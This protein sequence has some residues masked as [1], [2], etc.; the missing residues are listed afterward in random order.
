[1]NSPPRAIRMPEREPRIC[2]AGA[3]NVDL[4]AKVS[5]IPA[6]GETLPADAF[7]VDC[8]G[9]GGNQAVMARRLGARVTMASRVGRDVFGERAVRNYEDRGIDTAFVSWDD[10][11]PSGVAAI[12]VDGDGRNAIVY[13]PGANYALTPAHIRAAG[14][15]IAQAD[16]VV[17]QLEIPPATTQEALAIAR[18]ARRP[19]TIL[20]PAP[21]GAISGDL[22]ELCDV[23]VP[24]ELEAEALTGVAVRTLDDAAAAARRLREAGARAAV[25]TLG[26]R[27]ALIADE[28]GT[29]H[30]PGLRVGAVDTTG[31]GDA[32][33]GTLAYLLG[34]GATLR[35]AARFA[36]AAAALSVTKIGT[37]ASF[38]SRA[39]VEELTARLAN[40]T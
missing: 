23:I 31:A 3:T 27:G 12:L 35:E 26:A 8:G 32:F 24:N 30:I 9:K 20:N 11:Q 17:S 13:V 28:G 25:I 16:A 5:R 34:A 40:I 15:A 10:E 33:I 7:H 39:E 29:A 38:P 18:R 4:I 6:I 37:Q 2:V 22:I 14:D 1:M 21:A 36:N 19:V